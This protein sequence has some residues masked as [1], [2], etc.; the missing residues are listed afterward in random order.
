M[1]FKDIILNLQQHI[2]SARNHYKTIKELFNIVYLSRMF[3]VKM[4]V[5]LHDI[6][7]VHSCLFVHPT[8]SLVIW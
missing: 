8:V 1:F 3:V 7:C 6:A 5:Y 4:R 2:V